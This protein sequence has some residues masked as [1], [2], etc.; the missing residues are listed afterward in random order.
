MKLKQVKS[1]VKELL[2][3]YPNLRDDKNLTVVAIWRDD[4]NGNEKNISGWDLMK[5]MIEGRVSDP[6]NI[7]R[8]WQKLQQEHPELRGK[9]YL[10]RHSKLEPDVK[11]QI[12]NYKHIE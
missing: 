8:N 3:K 4:L 11:E 5:L 10:E 1:R 6:E 7:R 12:I 9:K 2:T